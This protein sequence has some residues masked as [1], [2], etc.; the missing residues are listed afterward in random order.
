MHK[1]A[2][3]CTKCEEGVPRRCTAGVEGGEPQKFLFPC[4]F[5]M[6]DFDCVVETSSAMS[7]RKRRI[8]AAANTKEFGSIS[9]EG[10]CQVLN[11]DTKD[12]KLLEESSVRPGERAGLEGNFSTPLAKHPKRRSG[13][14]KLSKRI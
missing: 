4:W 6:R 8:S 12:V 1:T 3:G 14:V 10:G 5:W 11:S 7:R 2:P 13:A 9:A